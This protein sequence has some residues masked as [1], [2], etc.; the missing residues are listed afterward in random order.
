MQ[1]KLEKQDHNNRLKG[2]LDEIRRKMNEMQKGEIERIEFIVNE[3][4]D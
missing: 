3:H 1:N 4:D 2:Q